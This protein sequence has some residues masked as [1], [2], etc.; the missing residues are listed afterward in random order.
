MTITN[1]ANGVNPKI[2]WTLPGSASPGGGFTPDAFSI[3]IFDRGAK[4]ANGSDDVIHQANLL[5]TATSYTLPSVLSSGQTLQIGHK[6]SIN[7]QIIDTRD[8][9]SNV[10][11]NNELARSLS[12]F[13][14][15]PETSSVAPGNISLPMVD[16]TTGIYHFNVG[17]VGPDSVTYIDPTIAV[18]YQ[19][20][21]G[22]GDPNF[23]S[24]I[25]PDVGGG[26]FNLS[27]L[28]T[29]VPLDAG[30]QYFFPTG[31]VSDFAVTGIDPLADL[32]PADTSAFVTGLT[33][34]RDGS[35]TGTMTPL[36]EDVAAVPEPAS[37]TLLAFGL[38]GCAVTCRRRRKSALPRFAED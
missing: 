32:D 10:T 19:Y 27:Y 23:A 35:F 38:L 15:T 4:L 6:Y 29:E 12:F 18:G 16:G 28:S 33:F 26:M 3:L 25:L 11:T 31:G 30:I 7:F 9:T 14:F 37:L 1:S 21:I 13:D 8:G 5:P 24:V 22:T 34:V 20:A 36:T 17:S 2:S